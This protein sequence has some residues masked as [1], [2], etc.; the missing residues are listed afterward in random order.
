LNGRTEN[1]S[2]HGIYRLTEEKLALDPAKHNGNVS[3]GLDPVGNRRSESSSLAGVPLGTFSFNAD[4]QLSDESYDV[5]VSLSCANLKSNFGSF[6]IV[7]QL[8]P[9]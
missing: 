7:G 2:Y 4:D 1:W 6:L 3:Y 8:G 5:N 9:R